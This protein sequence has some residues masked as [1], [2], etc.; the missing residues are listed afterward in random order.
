MSKFSCI[1][2]KISR[3]WCVIDLFAT[4]VRLQ[5]RNPP[6]SRLQISYLSQALTVCGLS[7]SV[8]MQYIYI[9]SFF[10]PTTNCTFNEA[11]R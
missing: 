3:P 1:D 2:L 6:L 5:M 4:K 9:C 7:L 11:F 10:F 8:A